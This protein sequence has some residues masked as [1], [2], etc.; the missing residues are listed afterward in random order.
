MSI[1]G[2]VQPKLTFLFCWWNQILIF[3]HC[4]LYSVV[5]RALM[6]QPG[7]NSLSAVHIVTCL[8]TRYGVWVGNQIYWTLTQLVTTLY[9]SVIC[10][11]LFSV[12][13]WFTRRCFTTVVTRHC[14]VTISNNGD[15]TTSHVSTRGRL[16][17]DNLRLRHTHPLF[18]PLPP[19]FPSLRFIPQYIASA[20]TQ[21]RTP[22]QQFLSW[23]F[24]VYLLL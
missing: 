8:V 21:Q 12:I 11:L 13:Y 1:F 10:T 20:W 22:P 3:F 17:H 9:K 19:S 14:Y 15:S 2:A 18:P 6:L 23:L 24:H 5:S 7:N 16:S 4:K